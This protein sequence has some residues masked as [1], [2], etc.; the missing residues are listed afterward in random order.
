MLL[1]FEILR[2]KF[3][4]LWQIV[5]PVNQDYLNCYHA[6]IETPA[7]HL[8]IFVY[9]SNWQR[10]ILKRVLV[11]FFCGDFCSEIK[12]RIM[13]WYCNCL[14]N[15]IQTL[16]DARVRKSDNHKLN[17]IHMWT[18]LVQEYAHAIGKSIIFLS[19]FSSSFSF[20]EMLDN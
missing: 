4:I 19:I 6:K 3:I 7:S 5:M 11:L 14:F 9:F 8:K 10:L 20:K 15:E 16:L 12:T 18:G 17:V 2:K 1:Q 13:S